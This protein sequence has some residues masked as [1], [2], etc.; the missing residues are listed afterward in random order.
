MRKGKQAP[1]DLFCSP[2][3]DAGCRQGHMSEPIEPVRV[4]INV[5][6]G[7]FSLCQEDIRVTG[8]DSGRSR[9][10]S[11]NRPSPKVRRGD[12]GSSEARCD[13]TVSEFLS[14]G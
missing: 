4:D 3:V 5:A 8:I 12:T 9:L 13:D 14:L 7:L 2:K 11:G 6:S 10:D 1:A